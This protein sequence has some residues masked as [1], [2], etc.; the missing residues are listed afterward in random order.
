MHINDKNNMIEIP[1]KPPVQ[2]QPTP[3]VWQKK[4]SDSLK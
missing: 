4:Q 3:S 1:L 2:P